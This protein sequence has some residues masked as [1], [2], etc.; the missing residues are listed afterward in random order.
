V[1][2]TRTIDRMLL[3][4]TSMPEQRSILPPLGLLYLAGA[5]RKSAEP[6]PDL[7]VLDYGLTGCDTRRF[8]AVISEFDPDLVGLSGLTLEADLISLAARLARNGRGDRLVVAGGPHASSAPGDTITQGK[9]DAAVVGE[10]ELTFPELVRCWREG[11][12]PSTV[13]GLALPGEGDPR[14]T[15]KR[16]PLA[17]LD[18][19]PDP[20]WDLIDIDS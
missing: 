18:D 3:V 10:G 6:V 8:S 12:D 13:P 11:G 15:D 7:R 9:L 14:F 5:L 2:Q 17:D 4:R 20:A 16:E 1:S 19:L